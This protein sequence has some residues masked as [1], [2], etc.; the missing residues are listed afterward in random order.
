MDRNTEFTM[1]RQALENSYHLMQQGI[2]VSGETLTQ[3][4]Q[5]KAEYEAAFYCLS[6]RTQNS[7]VINF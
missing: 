5:A 1:I 2:E 7:A 4:E 3:L 6:P